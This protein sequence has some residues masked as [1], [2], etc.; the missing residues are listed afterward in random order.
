MAPLFTTLCSTW[1]LYHSWCPDIV[2]AKE[3]AILV[4]QYQIDFSDQHAACWGKRVM[5]KKAEPDAF[6]VEPCSCDHLSTPDLLD[7]KL[8]VKLDYPALMQ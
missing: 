6:A 3:G 7:S 1:Y 2:F 4:L 5:S 8:D